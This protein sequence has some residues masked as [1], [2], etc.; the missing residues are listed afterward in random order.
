MQHGFEVQPVLLAQLGGFFL[1]CR[2]RLGHLV[3]KG[4]HGHV[5][6]GFGGHAQYALIKHLREPSK[7]KRVAF[8]AAPPVG[9]ENAVVAQGGAAA[10][11]LST[12]FGKSARRLPC[13]CSGWTAATAAAK[14]SGRV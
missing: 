9:D 11:S 4:E 8:V 1:Q 7:E 3:L 6:V 14:A 2:Q 13:G 5:A 12:G 10:I